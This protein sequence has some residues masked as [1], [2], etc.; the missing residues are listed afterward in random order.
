MLIKK[1]KALV[2]VILFLFVFSLFIPVISYGIDT[3]SIYVWSNNSSSVP[4]SNTTT[5]SSEEAVTEDTSR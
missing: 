2:F 1:N 4:T 3:D 5:D